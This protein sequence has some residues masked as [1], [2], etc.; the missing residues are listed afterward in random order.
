MGKNGDQSSYEVWAFKD[1]GQWV[2]IVD[3]DNEGIFELKPRALAAAGAKA[4]QKGVVEV[5]LVERAVIASFN[6]EAISLKGQL[7]SG[8]GNRKKKEMS[9]GESSHD[10]H[11]DRPPEDAVADPKGGHEG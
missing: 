2:Q 6:G 5:I 10:V 9:D 3:G 1:D 4:R 11:G 7:M 8:G